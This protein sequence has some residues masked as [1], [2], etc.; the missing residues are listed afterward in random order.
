VIEE[1]VRITFDQAMVIE[2]RGGVLSKEHP[3]IK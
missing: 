3:G 1:K 2:E